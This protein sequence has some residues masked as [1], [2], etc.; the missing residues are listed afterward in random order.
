MRTVTYSPFL[1]AATFILL[2]TITALQFMF[3]EEGVKDVEFVDK[4]EVLE[5]IRSILIAVLLAL[6]IRAFFMEVFLVQGQSMQPTLQDRERLIVNKVSLYYRLPR[7]GE[8]FVF[9]AA[10]R[11]DFIKR[12][13]GLP[14]D[15]V[16]VSAGG[17]YVNGQRIDE[18][19]VYDA[20]NEQFGPVI[21]PDGSVFVLGDNRDNSMDS[22]HPG[23]G[24]IPLERLKGKAVLVFWPPGNIRLLERP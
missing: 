13:I 23:V 11:R 16:L 15:E 1:Q 9:N 2:H 8:I 7:R 21:V 5:W 18:P 14:G 12:V 19:Y 20:A 3:A 22:R 4:K 24:F 6:V 17:T 10:K